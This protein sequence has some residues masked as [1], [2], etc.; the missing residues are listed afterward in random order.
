MVFKA[1]TQEQAD[2]KFAEKALK[3]IILSIKEI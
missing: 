3:D 1:P 2:K